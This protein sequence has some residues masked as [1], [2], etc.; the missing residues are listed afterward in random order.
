MSSGLHPPRH[1]TPIGE[2]AR[3]LAGLALAV[4]VFA[5]VLFASAWAIGGED[6]VSDNWVGVSVVVGFFAGLLGSFVA[7]VAAIVAGLR[8]E[9]W[10]RLWLPLATFPAVAVVVVLLEALVFE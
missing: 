7:L 1:P 8:R 6:A 9:P 4:L 3:R 2:M 5:A 10:S